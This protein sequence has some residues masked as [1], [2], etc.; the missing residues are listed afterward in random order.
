V[1]G[2]GNKSAVL[3]IMLLA[4]NCSYA[5][6]SL[7]SELIVGIK[8]DFAPYEFVDDE[9]LPSGFHIDLIRAVCDEIGLRPEFTSGSWTNLI[10]ALN[11]NKI[12][13][14]AGL[15]FTSERDSLVD[16][17]IPHSHI[18]QSV[19]IRKNSRIN[20]VEDLRGKEVIV[21]ENTVLSGF[22][23]GI[24]AIAVK[25]DLTALELLSSGQH[26]AVIAPKLYGLQLI[27]AYD[28]D[29]IKSINSTIKTYPMCFA[30]D[31][32]SSDLLSSLNEGLNKIKLNGTYRKIYDQWF[33]I[34]DPDDEFNLFRRTF[35]MAVSA[36]LLVVSGISLWWFTLRRAVLK[37]TGY[38]NEEIK[39]RKKIE[40]EI[41]KS[42]LK[43][44]ELIKE[45]DV[46]L[47]EVH[48]RVKNNLQILIS[49]NELQR[50]FQ[51]DAL[52][53]DFIYSNQNRI[54]M[55]TL[56]H[57]H[58]YKNRIYSSIDL[59]KYLTELIEYLFN[60]NSPNH[61]GISLKVS[62]EQVNV[63]LDIIIPVALIVSEVITNSLKYAFP[64]K[65]GGL[66]II[67]IKKKNE[68]LFIFLKDNGTGFNHTN[69]DAWT[70]G[71][72]LIK[73]LTANLNGSLIIKT[74]GGTSYSITLPCN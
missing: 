59:K 39:E 67:D 19:F 60:I 66:V 27:S 34:V 22:L 10:T 23:N 16:F 53:N 47:A 52:F 4:L 56:I 12:D 15:E 64:T 72:E 33:S 26:D 35:I 71:L 51:S 5:A 1:N 25:N 74:E 2:P 9:G 61:G 30:V 32:G 8:S 31:E 54:Y 42:K 63:K 17:S 18:Y 37:K 3:I 36:V 11:N 57:E 20:S 65:E 70:P 73:L 68:S 62:I 7:E 21:V 50:D 6:Y 48:H 14:L 69:P 45:K 13:M 43:T 38:L 29:N 24:T 41:I 46:L 40:N 58:L 55:I 49:L 44:G 28:I